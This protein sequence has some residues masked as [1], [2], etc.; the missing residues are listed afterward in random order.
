[1]KVVLANGCYDLF[2]YGHLLHLQAARRMGDR[3]VVSVTDDANVNKPDRPVFKDI[4]RAEIIRSLRCV[5]QVVIV[6]GLLDALE[7]VKPD[8]L[9]KG[10]DYSAL[11]PDHAAYCVDHDI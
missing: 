7:K 10:K 1:M 11:E 6:S 5:D 9:V 8:I 3:L 2:H 4:H